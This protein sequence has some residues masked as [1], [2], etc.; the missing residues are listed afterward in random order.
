LTRRIKSVP[1][2]AQGITPFAYPNLTQAA[3]MLGVKPPVLSRRPKLD[4][5]RAGREHRIPAA[6]V[7]R[8]TQYFRRR[9]VDEVAF[10][11]VVYCQ[12]HAPQAEEIVA[13]EVDETVAAIYRAVPEPSVEQFLRD[14]R[15]FLP[16]GL[17]G[18]VARAV[19]A[20]EIAPARTLVNGAPKT[21]VS[22]RKAAAPGTSVRNAS[23]RR[24]RDPV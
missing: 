24:P 9:S 13:A 23:K 21:K 3:A 4:F 18:Q 20:D 7:L 15:R 5:I 19:M 16:S 11:L 22:R 6:E 2:L 12:A 17:F 8:L 1:D 10:D 14:A